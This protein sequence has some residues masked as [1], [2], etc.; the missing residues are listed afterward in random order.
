MP[1]RVPKRLLTCR[2]YRTTALAHL[3]ISNLNFLE[4]SLFSDL[5]PGSILISMEKHRWYSRF[6]VFSGCTATLVVGDGGAGG[7][8]PAVVAGGVVLV[9]TSIWRWW[10]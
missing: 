5:I 7:I 2:A 1:W 9:I 8:S 3:W 6:F 4:S 10:F